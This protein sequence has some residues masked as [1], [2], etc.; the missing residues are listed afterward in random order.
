MT[1][2]WLVHRIEAAEQQPVRW[3]CFMAYSNRYWQGFW[4]VFD[5]SCHVV[6]HC[7]KAMMVALKKVQVLH[8]PSTWLELAREMSSMI[9]HVGPFLLR[10][11]LPWHDARDEID[12]EWMQEWIRG[13]A[14]MPASH[15]IP[16]LDTNHPDMPV[17]FEAVP[18]GE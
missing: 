6:G 2:F 5:G 4:V 11:L 3:D 15:P 10:A 8:S 17:P 18:A 9:Y 1:A 13:Y 7:L 12:P 14:N 16:L